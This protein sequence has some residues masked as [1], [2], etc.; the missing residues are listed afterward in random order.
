MLFG[1]MDY[2]PVGFENATRD[3][4]VAR[5]Q[6]PMVLGT[7]AHH[8]AMYAIYD[9][10]IQM[11]ADHPTAYENDP[12]FDFIRSIPAAWDETRFLAGAP[13]EWIA[14]A[15]RRGNDWYLGAMTGWTPRDVEIPLSFLSA[16]HYTAKTY[17]DAADADRFPKKVTIDSRPLA[18][19]ATLKIHLAPGGGF[20][21]QLTPS[22]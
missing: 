12:S 17:A 21:A 22:R 16:A 4:F 9:A 13:G 1:L 14:L 19:G 15:R 5:N 6:R 20:A 2:T 11:V 3:Q 8:L 18:R 10:P 7:R